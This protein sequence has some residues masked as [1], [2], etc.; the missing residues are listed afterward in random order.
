MSARTSTLTRVHCHR[1]E[2]RP[3]D[4]RRRVAIPIGIGDAGHPA[5]RTGVVEQAMPPLHDFLADR[6]DETRSADLDGF[7]TLGHAAHHQHRLVQ[8]R[9]LLLNAIRVGQ[10]QIAAL[11]QMDEGDVTLRRDTMNVGETAQYLPHRAGDIGIEVDRVDD[12]DIATL[13]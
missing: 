6:A 13:R 10:D 11:H 2:Q 8:G 4:A 1:V 12:F 7:G 9:C 3:H 5:R